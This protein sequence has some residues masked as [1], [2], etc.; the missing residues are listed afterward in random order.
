[1]AKIT[2]LHRNLL[3]KK[4]NKTGFKEET[5]TSHVP[6]PDIISVKQLEDELCSPYSHP[7][8][9]TIMLTERSCARS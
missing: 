5:S 2:A 9:P 7:E 1:M 8:S 3:Q 6:Q 4:I